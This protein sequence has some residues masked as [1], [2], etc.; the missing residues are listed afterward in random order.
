VTHL[1]RNKGDTVPPA[2]VTGVKATPGP[3]GAVSLT[4][5]NPPDAARTLVVRGP[6]STCPHFPA[7]GTPVGTRRLRDSQVDSSVQSTGAHCYAVYAFDAAGN[8]S[9]IVTA[10]AAPAEHTTGSPSPTPPPSQTGSSGSWL[11]DA[12]GLVGGGAVVLAGLA[13]V[14]LRLLRREWEWHSRTG[15][16]IRDLMSIDV[17]DYDRTALV[18]PAIIGVCVAGAVLALLLSL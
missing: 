13:F 17:R 8:R 18:I 9:T 7:D 16:G 2:A 4:W 14:T 12:V 5:T 6:G 11:P 15:Y 1:A 3:G 10:T